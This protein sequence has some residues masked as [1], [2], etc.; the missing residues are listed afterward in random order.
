MFS[1][2][3]IANQLNHLFQTANWGWAQFAR[4]DSVYYQSLPVKAQDA[5]VIICTI[6][7]SPVAPSQT[8]P[9]QPVPKALLDTVGSL[10]DDPL[11]SDVQFIIPKRN[12]SLSNGR[13]IWASKKLLQR[14]EYF[15]TMFNSNFAE[16]ISEPVEHL[17]GTPRKAT[18]NTR[19]SH[20]QLNM[21]LDEFEDSDDEDDE[22]PQTKS[23]RLSSSDGTDDCALSLPD[24]NPEDVDKFETQS[25]ISDD[26]FGSPPT[27]PSNNTINIR[28]DDETNM[29]PKM[30]I[31]VRDAAYN[32]YRAMLYY[33]YTDNVVF[34]P[35]SSSFLAA[36]L[37]PAESI[38]STPSEGCQVPGVR[39][40]FSRDPSSSRPEWIR[41]W[42]SANPGRPAPC[43]AKSM[44]RIAD[45]LNMIDLKERAAQH[46]LKSLT[47]DN[48]GYEVFSPFAAAFEAIRKVEVEFF[49]S[50][51]HEIR[52][53]ETMK[54][55]WL[56][57]RN[58]RHPGFE[59]VWPLIAQS[60]E[61]NPSTSGA[62]TSP[63][64]TDS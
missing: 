35:L 15:E 36:P 64:V 56:Q 18:Q 22:S 27:D 31:V 12:Q 29:A 5:F 51:W 39:R 40:V 2:F 4:R 11:Y 47:V 30:T 54:N 6:T 38:P 49:L 19:R 24:S 3:M 55:V 10:L 34:A 58:G 1:V 46:I 21:I 28:L 37:P 61:F 53:S 8:L 7:S 50:H 26:Q 45:R 14:S 62:P 59:E 48:I 42:M 17:L 16:G 41:D 52:A 23:R 33:V 44:Y 25:T 13:K 63:K 60:L 57:I 32:T 9:R 43:S 20:P